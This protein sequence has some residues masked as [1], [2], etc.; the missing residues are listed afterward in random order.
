MPIRLDIAPDLASACGYAGDAVRNMEKIYGVRLNYSLA[1]LAQVDR[2]LGEWREGGATLEAV[3][4]SLYAFGSYAGE[5]LLRYARG[6]WTEPKE[7]QYGNIDDLFLFVTLH[8]GREWRPI[9]IAVHAL[10]DGPEFSLDKSARELLATKA[11]SV[12]LQH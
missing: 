6:R 4:K 2:T 12:R 8:D 9:A 11:V 3:T 7:E 5:V 10:L 1:S